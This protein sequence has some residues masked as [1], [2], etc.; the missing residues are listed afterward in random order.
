LTDVA[1]KEDVVIQQASIMT[2]AIPV[3]GAHVHSYQH[4]LFTSLPDQQNDFGPFVPRPSVDN[5]ALVL[6]VDTSR[7]ISSDSPIPPH[8]EDDDV[9]EVP[10]F[11]ASNEPIIADDMLLP[12]SD[13]VMVFHDDPPH[14]PSEDHLSI[15]P[16]P[17]EPAIHNVEQAPI[18]LNVLCAIVKANHSQIASLDTSSLAIDTEDGQIVEEVLPLPIVAPSSHQTD[19]T[20]ISPRP[21]QLQSTSSQSRLVRQRSRSSQCDWPSYHPSSRHRDNSVR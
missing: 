3:S 18:A 10:T 17:D 21:Q 9:V 14:Q 16:P 13:D 12:S 11:H 1:T 5:D 4:R 2:L 6:Q 15:I 19:S 20:S 8:L 7:S